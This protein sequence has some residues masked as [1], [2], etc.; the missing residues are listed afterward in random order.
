MGWDEDQD[1]KDIYTE[2]SNIT[3]FPKI[4]TISP[5]ENRKIKI[6]FTARWPETE[7]S[8]RF[9]FREIPGIEPGVRGVQFALRMSIPVFIQPTQK[10][11]DPAI[12]LGY[13]KFSG[14]NL[15][16]NIKNNGTSYFMVDKV[17][18][19]GLN[20]F[21]TETFSKEINGWYVLANHSRS[22]PAA[23]KYRECAKTTTINVTAVAEIKAR[24]DIL[25]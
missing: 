1:G 3:Y 19:R 5:G 20:G 24:R 14:A 15:L 13:L 23:L 8:Y 22:F 11:V 16:V 25:T 10:P 17:R 9:F 4:F 7:N 18:L 2:T 6:A 12:E 21:G